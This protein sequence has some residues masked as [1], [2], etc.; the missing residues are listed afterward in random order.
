MKIAYAALSVTRRSTTFVM[1]RITSF[2][3]KVT[4]TGKLVIRINQSNMTIIAMCRQF[5]I[6]CGKCQQCLYPED[7]VMRTSSSIFHYGCFSCGVCG[8]NL[9]QGDEYMSNG[10]G[11]FICRDH[12]NLKTQLEIPPEVV[13]DGAQGTVLLKYGCRTH[14]T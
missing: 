7:L 3:A 11:H 8:I 4:T 9:R 1:S 2:T 13:A 6:K 10:P 5:R 12:F 14:V